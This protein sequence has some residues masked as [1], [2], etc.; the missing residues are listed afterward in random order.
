MRI[1]NLMRI[2][3]IPQKHGELEQTLLSMGEKIGKTKGCV[4]HRL[5][6]DLKGKDTFC[7]VD[8]WE[9]RED[10]DAYL[11]SD[12]FRVLIGAAG[13]LGKSHDRMTFRPVSK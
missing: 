13:V 7:V 4:E 5:Y 1:L 8:E 12:L 2:E 6:A 10:F 11:D 3:A 9:S